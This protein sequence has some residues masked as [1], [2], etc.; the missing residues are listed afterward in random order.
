[1]KK[2]IL[3]LLFLSIPLIAGNIGGSGGGL[4]LDQSTPQ[5]IENGVPLLDSTPNG[6]ADI[7]SIVNKEYV[8]LAVTSLGASYYMYSD[9]DGTGYRTCHLDPSSDTET[10]IEISGLT[11]DQYIAGWISGTG[12]EPAKL[13]KG[14]YD[15]YLTVEK[16]TGNQELRVYWKLFERTSGD[17]EIEIATSSYSNVITDKS[18]YIIPLQ[19]S[20]DYIPDENSRIVGKLYADV[21]GT[22]NAPT[23]RIYFQGSTSS[24]WEIP[25]NTEIF[26]NIFIPYSG[27]TQNIDLGNKTLTTTVA[28]S[29]GSF[30]ID[31]TFNI[32]SL[33]YDRF[34]IPYYL[35]KNALGS[36]FTGYVDCQL[37]ISETK[38]FTE[39]TTTFD[40][41]TDQEGWVY[42]SATTGE[43]T[44]WSSSGVEATDIMDIS[45][46]GQLPSVSAIRYVRARLYEHGTEN[47]GTWIPLGVYGSGIPAEQ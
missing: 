9:V 30:L 22:G 18:S 28:V 45:F 25:A 20:E 3:L 8:D 10:H 39:N 27:A 15:W 7:K 1:M 19:L 4:Q 23:L 29:A 24:R 34:T 44:D 6:N 36:E 35:W 5:T 43:Y 38:D 12:E 37:Q 32:Y 17:T 31:G 33:R 47:Y 40:S 14:V 46:D 13:L 2:T 26:K 41:G 16:T 21:S 11:D 42:F